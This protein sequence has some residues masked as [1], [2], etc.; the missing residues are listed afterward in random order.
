MSDIRTV[1]KLENEDLKKQLE[2][3]RSIIQAMSGNYH[4]ACPLCE[5]R[6]RLA[7]AE[8][9]IDGSPEIGSALYNDKLAD[10]INTLSAANSGFMCMCPEGEE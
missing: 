1:L 7:A 9:I 2:E 8:K 4:N 5:T 3:A 10:V 6:A